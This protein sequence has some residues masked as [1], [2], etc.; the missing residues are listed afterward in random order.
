[1]SKFAN[2]ETKLEV[3]ITQF[4]DGTY[5]GAVIAKDEEHCRTVA[6]VGEGPLNAL[7][8]AIGEVIANVAPSY[9]YHTNEIPDDVLP[10]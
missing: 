8:E 9:L 1:M 5:R 10:I 7:G 6:W 4:D 3:L 2:K